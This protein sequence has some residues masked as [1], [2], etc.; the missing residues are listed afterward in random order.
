MAQFALDRELSRDLESFCRAETILVALD[1]DGTLAPLVDDPMSARALPESVR[2]IGE[3]A[4]LE[5][6]RVA[7]VSGRDLASLDTLFPSSDRV[8]R[9]ASHGGEY[10]LDGEGAPPLSAAERER[11]EAL[12][13]GLAPPIA[14]VPGA[15]LERK[16]AGVAVHTR[17]A[18]PAQAAALQHAVREWITHHDPL[19]AERTGKDILEYS[20]LP[21]HKGEGIARLRDF[22]RADAVFYAGDD[23]TDEDAFAALRPGDLGV[24]CGFGPTLASR[25]IADPEEMASVL[26]AL[27]N[28]RIRALA[29]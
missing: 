20:V 23:V 28:F 27:V 29:A 22:T 6:T 17:L 13:A 24:K 3:L 19:L 25:R 11:V 18:D 9:I 7:L 16:P 26:R 1:F 8:L 15:A 2:A 10:R 4:E 12:A 5:R 21:A 14:A